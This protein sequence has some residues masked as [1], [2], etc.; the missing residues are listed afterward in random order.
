MLVAIVV[1]LCISIM[2]CMAFSKEFS[3]LCA[4]FLYQV[5]SSSLTWCL[6]ITHAFGNISL[7]CSL[8]W[9]WSSQLSQR[10]QEVD[11]FDFPVYVRS[12]QYNEGENPN[13]GNAK[14]EDLELEIA[15]IMSS[16][17]WFFCFKIV[18][19]WGFVSKLVTNNS[20]HTKTENKRQFPFLGVAK[21]F[22]SFK[23]IFLPFIFTYCIFS[24]SLHKT[25]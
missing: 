20:G 14:S 8:H 18:V 9:D 13:C 22:P 17:L 6:K 7:Y 15:F 4:M 21:Y 2:Q 24:P 19:F 3:V 1:S 12:P 23:S 11:I 16:H 25:K 10:S 5:V